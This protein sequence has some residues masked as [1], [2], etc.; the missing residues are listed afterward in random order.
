MFHPARTQHG[1]HSKES[2]VGDDT[3]YALGG[4]ELNSAQK[5]QF[6][7]S[8]ISE[9]QFESAARG[10]TFTEGTGDNSSQADSNQSGYNVSSVE[11]SIGAGTAT[12]L[13]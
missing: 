10:R 12:A 11:K 6:A 2:S 8:E 4:E 5:R 1:A 7:F 13:A 9:V 3:D